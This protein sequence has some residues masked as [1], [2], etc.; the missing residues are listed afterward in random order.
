MK[1]RLEDSLVAAVCRGSYDNVVWREDPKNAHG[2]AAVV[3]GAKVLRGLI[4]LRLSENRGE[5]TVRGRD[6]FG[7]KSE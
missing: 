6:V 4:S 5:I 2:V 3:T 7:P 1:E